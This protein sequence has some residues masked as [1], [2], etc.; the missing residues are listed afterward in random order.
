MY[1]AFEAW[2]I[3]K[4]IQ[5]C[6]DIAAQAALARSE[7]EEQ[8]A[9]SIELQANATW[10]YDNST[11]ASY[12]FFVNCVWCLKEKRLYLKYKGITKKVVLFFND[13]VKVPFLG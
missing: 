1:L 2:N 11:E 8:E 12:L 6:K 5:V 9:T 10:L 3:A 13:K 4:T 7:V